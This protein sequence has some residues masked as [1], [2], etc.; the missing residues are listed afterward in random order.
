MTTVGVD[1]GLSSDAMPSIG[2]WSMWGSFYLYPGHKNPGRKAGV[3]YRFVSIS[4][5]LSDCCRS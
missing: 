4:G 5:S 3:V 1:E 2:V